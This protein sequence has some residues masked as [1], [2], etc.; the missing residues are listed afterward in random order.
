MSKIIIYGILPPPY[1]GVSIYHKRL[2]NALKD[3]EVDFTFIRSNKNQSTEANYLSLR[4]FVMRMMDFNKK[5]IH[6]SGFGTGFLHVSLIVLAVLFRKKVIL[7]IHNDRISKSFS[8][9]AP[10]K[11]L[12]GWLFLKT[13]AHVISVNPK[14]KIPFVKN[15]KLSVI[16]AYISPSTTE[17]TT[18]Q[19]PA[20]FHNLRT[21][22]K[23]L[24]TA[25]ASKVAF[26]NNED[27]YG[28]DLSIELMKR[29]KNKGYN[30]VGF[31]YVIPE[32]GDHEY[33]QKMQELVLKHKLTEHFHLYT[34]PVPYP[35]VI[36]LCDLF[37]RP[38][39]TDGYGVSIAEAISLQVPAIAS[40]VCPRPEGTLLFENRNMSDLEKK[41]EDIIN[42]YDIHKNRIRDV[43]Y[44]DNA[45]K[46]IEVYN[47]V[48]RK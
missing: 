12:I 2:M 28:I 32:I 18:N 8:C 10:H 15:E 21:K 9:L 24:I 3:K 44:E 33:Y 39:N 38:T 35:A 5:V 17:T 4:Q 19:L 13:T 25:S 22:H 29:L 46:I 41:T 48:L 45:Q 27:L 31:I 47:K 14:T 37:I 7:T 26:Y 36:N 30:N 16:P 43:S 11:K 23:F 34:Q 20:Y 6:I 42:N 40:D 1:G